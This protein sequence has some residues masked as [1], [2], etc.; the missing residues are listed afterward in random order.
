[1]FWVAFGMMFLGLTEYSIKPWELTA[2]TK[3]IFKRSLIGGAVNVGLNLIL[4]KLLG[5]YYIASVTTFIGFFVYFLLARYG[6]RSQLR[7]KLKG[8]SLFRILLSA[9]IMYLAIYILKIFMPFNK[10]NLVLFVFCGMI[11]YGL[12]LYISGEVK[13]EANLVLNKIIKSN[14]KERKINQMKSICVIGIGYVGLP[15]AAM[16]ASKGH[17]VIGYDLNKR[18]LTHLTEAKLL[19]RSQVLEI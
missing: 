8:K 7:W 14:F 2:N 12:V 6:T 13:N 1:M 5:S 10:I 3:A 19:L 11:V 4:I 18:L 9:G 17:K 16:F 15:T